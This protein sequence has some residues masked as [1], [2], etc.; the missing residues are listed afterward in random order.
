MSQQSVAHRSCPIAYP[1]GEWIIAQRAARNGGLVLWGS[2]SVRRGRGLV[3]L[4]DHAPRDLS[5]GC[6]AGWLVL[7]PHS[8]G[9]RVCALASVTGRD[10]RICAAW[11]H[12]IHVADSIVTDGLAPAVLEA[13]DAA[14]ELLRYSFSAVQGVEGAD[15]VLDAASRLAERISVIRTGATGGARFSWQRERSASALDAIGA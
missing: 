2:V 8:E 13:E 1:L 14:T 11:V 7:Q 10:G 15:R 12:G 5:S 3:F 4:G 9:V 6:R